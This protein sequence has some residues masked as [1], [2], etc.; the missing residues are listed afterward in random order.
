VKILA[1]LLSP[2][3]GRVVV[4]GSGP[5]NSAQR[6]ALFGMVSP[7]LQL[8]DEFTGKENLRLALDIR[9]L[10]GGEEELEELL[11]LVNLYPR[12]NDFVRTYSSGMKQ[13]IKYAFA[14][15]HRPSILLL[16]EPMANLDAEGS[17][18][19]RA[20]MAR[21]RERGMLVVATNDR[22]DVEGSDLQ[23]N[24]DERH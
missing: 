12:R 22:S 10:P 15:V 23:V 6:L 24:L 2:S 11:N 8:Y 18:L 19:A 3:R 13:R 16:D 14:L 20:V 1:G 7:Y 17:A 5:G 9:G 4:D 21:P